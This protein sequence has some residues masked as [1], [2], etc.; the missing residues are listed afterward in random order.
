MGVHGGPNIESDATVTTYSNEKYGVHT[1]LSS[2]T[3]TTMFPVKCDILVVAG[4]GAGGGGDVGG[5]G[6]AGGVKYYA[7]KQIDAGTYTVTI[8]AGGAGTSAQSPS[9]ASHNGEDSLFDSLTASGGGGANSWSSNRNPCDGGSGGGCGKP[10]GD[11]G[12]G[13]ANQGYDGGVS[14]YVSGGNYPA[15]GGGGASAVGVNGTATVAG[16]GGA[17]ITEGSSTVYD[18]TKADGSTATFNINGTTNSYGGG[19]GGGRQDGSLSGTVVSAVGGV[20]GGGDGYIQTSTGAPNGE[21]GDA[22]TGGGGGGSDAT[23]GN[24]GSGIVIV[25]LGAV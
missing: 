6:G 13:V 18:W 23:G 21:N 10:S 24:G 17:G 5:G 14:G 20:G 22:N 8:G 4:G 25:R 1:F 16:P 19:G 11:A 7:S 15:A 3:F 12:S 2:G 9:C